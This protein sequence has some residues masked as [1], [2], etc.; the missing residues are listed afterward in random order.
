M[1]MISS[2]AVAKPQS[3]RGGFTSR[4]MTRHNVPSMVYNYQCRSNINSI[5]GHFVSGSKRVDGGIVCRSAAPTSGLTHT[6][7]E[8]MTKGT[9]LTCN[10]DTSIDDAL[11]MLV[12]NHVTGLPVVDEEKVVVGIISDFDLLCL[13]GVS[14]EEK[15]GGLFPTADDDWNSFFEVQKLVEKNAGKTVGDVMTSNPICVRASTSVASAAHLLLHKRIRRLPVVDDMGRLLG[16][17]TRSNV[18]KAAWESRKA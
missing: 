10:P 13:E 12:E 9:L 1:S 11:E 14:E 18:I 5:L 15:K 7:E 6:V 3:N 8:I 4:T 16:I 17:I 2:S